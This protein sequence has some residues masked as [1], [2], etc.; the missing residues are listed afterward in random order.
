MTRTE[1][2]SAVCNY[3]ISR[4]DPDTGKRLQQ[5]TRLTNWPSFCGAS[6]SVTNDDKKVTFAAWTGFMTADLVDL[7]AGGTR[8]TNVRS[9]AQ[10]ESEITSYS[11]GRQTASPSSSSTVEHPTAMGFT[12]N[13]STRRPLSLYWR[14]LTAAQ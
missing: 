1:A 4:I 2:D 7:E 14:L 10:E 9:F 11:T 13:L 8:L 5:P 6:G 3:W 12:S